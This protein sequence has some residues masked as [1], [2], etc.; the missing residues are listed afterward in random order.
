MSKPV[1][2]IDMGG[3]KIKIGLVQEETILSYI[4]IDADSGKGLA[5]KLP[6]IQ[7]TIENLLSRHNL[8]NS[9][10]A[11]LGIASP[12]IVDSIQKKILSIDKKFSDAPEINL[13]EWCLQAFNLPFSIENDARSALIGEWK[14]GKAKTYDN[15]V[16]MTLGTG[17]GSAVVMESQLLKGKHFTAGILGGHSVINYKGN[18]CNCGNKG[19]VET[20]AS[21]WNLQTIAEMNKDFKESRLAPELVIDYELIFRLAE[22][23]DITAIA[24]RDQ[25]LQA[26]SACAINLIHA[27]DPEVL[28]LT[29]GIMASNFYIL[30]YIRQHIETH[31]WTPWGKVQIE[32]GNF[33]RTAALLGITHLINH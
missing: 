20:E 22:E 1:I 29:G 32:E 33:P 2:A 27:Y 28:I 13:E 25:S 31:A 3:T 8:T 19:C 9:D 12:G 21:T 15:I 17:I 7:R 26:W 11:G 14:Y 24:I 30:P 10:I 5:A 16:L 23:G 4:S 6:F 18:L